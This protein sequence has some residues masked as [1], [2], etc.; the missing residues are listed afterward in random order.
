MKY[1]KKIKFLEIFFDDIHHKDIKLILK[2]NGLFVFPV[3]EPL[4]NFK[5]NSPYH[6]SLITQ[7]MFFFG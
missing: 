5:I 1:N 7:T 6:K 2:S 4:A 3:P